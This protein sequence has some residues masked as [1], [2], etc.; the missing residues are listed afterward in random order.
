MVFKKSNNINKFNEVA[1][2]HPN[3]RKNNLNGNL[4]SRGNDW[5]T[6]SKRKNEY[7]SSNAPI[8]QRNLEMRLLKGLSEKEIR[9]TIYII[10]G[11]DGFEDRNLRGKISTMAQYGDC[12]FRDW[13]DEN[14]ANNNLPI[15]WLECKE[16]IVAY[17]TEKNINNIKMYK[18]EKYSDFLHRCN[19]MKRLH[20][21]DKKDVLRL[22]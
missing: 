20:N 4:P 16:K 10:E 7:P 19:D 13:I 17:C 21:L 3:Q 6:Y 8:N 22:I 2:A 15:D 9:R 12:E 14:A 18:D 1:Q 11:E 5:E